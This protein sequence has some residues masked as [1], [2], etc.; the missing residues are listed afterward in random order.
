M[1]ITWG[2]IGMMKKRK[3]VKQN[4]SITRH[5]KNDHGI[6]II[7]IYNKILPQTFS[8]ASNS[9]NIGC[10]KNMSRDL[11]HRA[12]TSVSASCTV[13]MVRLPRAVQTQHKSQ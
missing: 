2:E 11:R 7:K 13:F 10:S 5:H 6:K 9:S 12:F 1:D 8:G 4:D 3:K